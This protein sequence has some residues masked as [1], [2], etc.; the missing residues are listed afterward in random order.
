MGF[1]SPEYELDLAEMT[2]SGGASQHQTDFIN[3]KSFSYG[4]YMAANM[5]RG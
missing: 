1:F 4:G 2:G 3:G 5:S